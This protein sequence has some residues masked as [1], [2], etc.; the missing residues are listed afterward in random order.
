[1][2]YLA[3][4]LNTENCKGKFKYITVSLKLGVGCSVFHYVHMEM[5]TFLLPSNQERRMFCLTYEASMT[6]L[7][8]EGRTETVR[9]CTSESCAFVRAL[10]SGEVVRQASHHILTDAL[11]NLH[12]I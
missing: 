7:F 6:R 2:L 5:L 3:D 11:S 10:D 1:M 12:V 8:K 4:G 9:S